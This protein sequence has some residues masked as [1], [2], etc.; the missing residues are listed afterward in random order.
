LITAAVLILAGSGW[1]GRLS[2][3]IARHILAPAFADDS[4]SDGGSGGGGRGGNGSGSGNGGGDDDG[5][6]NSSNGGAGTSG[7]ATSAGAAPSGASV[8]AGGRRTD[9]AAG[10][11]VVVGDRPEVLATAEGLGFRLIDDRPLAALGL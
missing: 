3:D 2:S 4:G 5:G 10:E 11:V 7:G 9:F 6:D 1:H 8:N